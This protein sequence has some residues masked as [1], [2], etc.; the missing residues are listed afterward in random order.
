MSL[1]YHQREIR[2]MLLTQVKISLA[3][4]ALSL[5][6]AGWPGLKT[7]MI[8]C[9]V[10]WIP[11]LCS[12]KLTFRYQGASAAKQIMRSLYRGEALK[13]ALSVILFA[14]AFV[15]FTLVPWIF[16][17]VYV[18]MQLMAWLMLMIVQ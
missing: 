18:C 5:V 4:L 1:A 8:A 14:L 10:Y 2:H 3:L 16:F 6:L 13:I 7:A 12:L 9:A 17:G 11:Y 15:F